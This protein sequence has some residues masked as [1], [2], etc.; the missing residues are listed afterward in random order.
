MNKN[1]IGIV[2]FG[3]LNFTKLAVEGIRA[4]VKNP[5]ELSS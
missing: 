3:N 1:L 5:Y 4:T 2:T